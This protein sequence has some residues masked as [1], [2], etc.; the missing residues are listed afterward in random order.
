MW[1]DAAV[2]GAYM[3]QRAEAQRPESSNGG[4]FGPLLGVRSRVS[5]G[6]ENYYQITVGNFS[7][8]DM[9]LYIYSLN[10]N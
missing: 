6:F 3:R 10:A 5:V 1:L 2:T 7:M 9:V 8:L 4:C